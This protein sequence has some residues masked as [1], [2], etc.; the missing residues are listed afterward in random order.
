MASNR[1]IL[2]AVKGRLGSGKT[3]AAEFLV[4]HHGFRRVSFAGPLKDVAMRITPDGQID[5]KRDRALL[6]FLGTEY[7][8]GIDPDYWVKKFIETTRGLLLNGLSVVTDDCR[9]ANEKAAI[10]ALG[11]YI[12]FVSTPES[13]IESNILSRDGAINKGIAG[14]ASEADNDPNDPLIDCKID[15]DQDL[16]TFLRLVNEAVCIF[17]ERPRDREN[18]A[19]STVQSGPADGQVSHS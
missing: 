14:H 19:Q 16:Q 6:Q 10:K 2:V 8:R 9:F 4:E 18:A 13:K 11:G 5:K 7:F 12:V 1:P 15:N 17:R 3:T